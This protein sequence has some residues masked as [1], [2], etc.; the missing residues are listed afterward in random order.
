MAFGAGDSGMTT[1]RRGERNAASMMRAPAGVPA[2]WL[3]YVVV[4]DL[5]AARERATKLGGKVMVPN[6]G[7]PG[8]GAFSVLQDPLGAVIAAFKDAG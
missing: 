4:D 1:L 2:H 6:I 5:A 8:I 3:S 7:V